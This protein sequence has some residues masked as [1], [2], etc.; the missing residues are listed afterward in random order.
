VLNAMKQFIPDTNIEDLKIH[1]SATA[2]DIKNHRE[3]VFTTGS[4][5]EAIRAS[6]AIPTVLTPVIKEDAIIVDGGVLNNVPISNVKRTKDDLLVTVYVNA[7]IPPL[8][9][10]VDKK[11]QKEKKSV[12]LNKIAEFYE[13]LSLTNA[14]SKKEKFS[15][16][17]LLDQT[18]VS[19]SLQLAQLQIEKGS[20][21]VLINISRD[22]CGTYDFYMA[23]ELVEIG[24]QSAAKILD[25]F[26]MKN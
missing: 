20:P 19:A 12:Y 8:K 15:Y 11:E 6:I 9:I 21:D 10:K 1:Y 14:K 7:D 17:T 18:F 3:V 5:Y 23:E 26:E 4:I 24:R 2:T 22:S 25:E 16:F 13:Y